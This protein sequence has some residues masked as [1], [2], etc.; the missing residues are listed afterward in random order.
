MAQRCEFCFNPTTFSKFSLVDWLLV[1]PKIHT[2]YHGDLPP[3]SGE[4]GGHVICEHNHLTLNPSS[5]RRISY[6]VRNSSL[7]LRITF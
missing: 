5:R 2:P 4:F 3:D 6:E 7:V 1:K